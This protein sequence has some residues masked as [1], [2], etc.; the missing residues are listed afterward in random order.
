MEVIDA[1]SATA[2]QTSSKTNA[3]KLVLPGGSHTTR[4]TH[5]DDKTQTTALELLRDWIG[6]VKE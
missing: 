1:W 3:L 4:L 5:F 2:V 6:S